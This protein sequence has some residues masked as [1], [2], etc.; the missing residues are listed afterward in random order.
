[1]VVYSDKVS[2]SARETIV[3]PT[4][5]AIRNK[6]YCLFIRFVNMSQD[7]VPS[8]EPSEIPSKIISCSEDT[9]ADCVIDVTITSIL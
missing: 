4:D 8:S 1:L 6:K 7:L 5:T 9:L 3:R 2:S